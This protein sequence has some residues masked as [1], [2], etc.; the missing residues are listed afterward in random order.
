MNPAKITLLVGQNCPPR[1]GDYNNMRHDIV[2]HVNLR[3][4]TVYVTMMEGNF[5][6]Q[7]HIPVA[8]LKLFGC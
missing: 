3:L 1:W 6:R 8:Y 5:P 2:S 4:L 7:Y